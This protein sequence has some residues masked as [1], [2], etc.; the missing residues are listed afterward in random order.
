[1]CVCADDSHWAC[2][3]PLG[4]CFISLDLCHHP[5]QSTSVQHLRGE[6][7]FITPPRWRR[8]PFSASPDPFVVVTDGKSSDWPHT[9]Y[10]SEL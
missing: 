4:L 5:R 10:S 2:I 9:V 8:S 6:L 7:S 1:M 3:D